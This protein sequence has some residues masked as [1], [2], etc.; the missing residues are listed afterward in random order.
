MGAGFGSQASPGRTG[1]AV[2]RLALPSASL[3]P[4]PRKASVSFPVLFSSGQRLP[5]MEVAA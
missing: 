3:L 5:T 4:A 1:Q 2:G